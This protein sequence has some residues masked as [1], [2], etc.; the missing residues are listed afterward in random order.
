MRHR[1][2]RVEPIAAAKVAGVLYALMGLVFV[3]IFA[4]VSFA[5]PSGSGFGMGLT[6]LMPIFYGV[7]GFVFTAIA[8][9]LYNVV[10]GWIGGIELELDTAPGV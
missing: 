8:A 1:I 3:P 2:R 5:A 6:I 9:A 10:A 7:M 4:V